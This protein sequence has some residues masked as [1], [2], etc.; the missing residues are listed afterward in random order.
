MAPSSEPSH[1]CL[2]PLE[3]VLRNGFQPT[4]ESVDEQFPEWLPTTG[5]ERTDDCRLLQEVHALCAM[6]L[7]ALEYNF[8]P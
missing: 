1:T 6:F 7:Y 8:F 2:Q 3:H 5:S 4:G